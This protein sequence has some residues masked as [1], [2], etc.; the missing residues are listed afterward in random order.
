MQPFEGQVAIVTGGASGIGRMLCEELAGRGASVVVADINEA[1]AT[2]VASAI[3]GQGGQAQAQVID[4]CSE[5]AV[6]HL[7]QDTAAA[8]GRLDYMFNNAGIVIAGDLRDLRTEHWR[9]M[10][11]VNL[12]GVIYGTSAAYTLMAEQGHGHIVNTA[13]LAG[14]VADPNDLVYTTTKHAVVGLSLSLRPQAAALGIKVSAVCPGYVQS[15]IYKTLEIVTPLAV[16]R[17][18]FL[19]RVISFKMVE[20]Q[21]AAHTILVGVARNRALIV[22][23]AHAR[24][25]WRLNRISYSLLEPLGRRMVDGSRKLQAPR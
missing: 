13:S 24:I 18:E 12:W 5:E 6:R 4:V 19:R 25:L 3:N 2:E 23:P 10:L 22:F 8:H 7:V 14:L 15:D 17:D 20:T 11:D 21:R 9:R 16:P 1:G